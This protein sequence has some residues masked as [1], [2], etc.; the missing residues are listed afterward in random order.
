[1]DQMEP[2]KLN[3]EPTIDRRMMILEKIV[4]SKPEPLKYQIRSSFPFVSTVLK[5]HCHIANFSRTLYIR[6]KE[7]ILELLSNQTL[8]AR[9]RGMYFEELVILTL[10]VSRKSNSEVDLRICPIK[11]LKKITKPDYFEVRIRVSIIN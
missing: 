5:Q 7:E 9:L 4:P 2:L 10:N 6:R 8:D 11:Y 3:Y 1:M